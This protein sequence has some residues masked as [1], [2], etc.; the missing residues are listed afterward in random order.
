MT[1][2][3]KMLVSIAIYEV[4]IHN[5]KMEKAVAMPFLAGYSGCRRWIMNYLVNGTGR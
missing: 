2:R 1:N 3:G 4:W 5:Q